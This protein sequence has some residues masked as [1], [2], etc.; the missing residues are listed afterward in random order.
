MFWIA[1]LNRHAELVER[2][3]DTLGVDLA[4]EA[5]RGRMSPEQIRTNVLNCVGCAYPDGCEKWLADH[6][7]GAS[8]TPGYCR[9]K[10][11]LDR[12]AA[13]Q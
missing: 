13:A 12:L 7:D 4:E 10:S 2:M 3:A 11:M 8:E 5:M 6:K 9:N 1:R